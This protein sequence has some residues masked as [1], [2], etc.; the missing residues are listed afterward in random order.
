MAGLCACGETT[1]AAQTLA[2]VAAVAD[3]ADGGAAPA[4]IGAAQAA[5]QFQGEA[6]ADNWFALKLHGGLHGAAAIIALSPRL[7]EFSRTPR[8]DAP[9]AVRLDRRLRSSRVARAVR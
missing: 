4:D 2:D 9:A 7:A 6:W 3:A 8:S 1:P 5:V